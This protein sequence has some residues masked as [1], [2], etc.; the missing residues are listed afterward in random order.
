MIIQTWGARIPLLLLAA[1]TGY[2]AYLGFAPYYNSF[3]LYVSLFFY[4]FFFQIK[5]SP[6]RG[7]YLIPYVWD[8]AFSF[9][10]LSWMNQALNFF[11]DLPFGVSQLVVLAI[12]LGL[13]IRSLIIAVLWNARARSFILFPL[14]FSGATYL[15]YNLVANFSWLNFAYTNTNQLG[16]YLAPIGGTYLVQFFQIAF[17]T[18]VYALIHKIIISRQQPMVMSL[19]RQTIDRQLRISWRTDFLALFLLSVAFVSF[20]FMHHQYTHLSKTPISVALVQPNFS[21]HNREQLENQPAM[22]ETYRN[23][24]SKTLND[25][26]VTQPPKLWILPESALM[27]FYS[28]DNNPAYA[29]HPLVASTLGYLSSIY[30]PLTLTH[31]DLV[32]G[33]LAVKTEEQKINN[34]NAALVL[35]NPAVL[36]GAVNA[37][38]R[39]E[40]LNG[41]DTLI[42]SYLKE[43]LVP[44]G[45][46]VPFAWLIKHLPIPGI[47]NQL[48]SPFIAGNKYQ[49]NIKTQFSQAA[50]II[51]Y[52]ALFSEQL[53]RQINQDTS[54]L[55]NI[56]N[57]V[58]FGHEQG[59]AQH[60]NV[61]RF[62][63]LESQRYT[64]RAT[65]NGITAI[66][67]PQGQIENYLPQN[68]AAVLVG[69]Y[70]NATGVTPYQEYSRL[71]NFALAALFLLA[72]GFIRISVSL[73]TRNNRN[74]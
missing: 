10:T 50:M 20:H 3:A 71:M 38:N 1:F 35:T 7:S 9:A 11:G 6:K 2:F 13:G 40:E 52:D 44:F 17:I 22:V 31:S 23:L 59:P 19:R 26:N 47:E 25:P 5:A 24:I 8:V 66:I 12:S 48:A 64:L 67:N 57:D 16:V 36:P 62:R 34:Y 29:Q 53:I 42:Q 65:N 37:P 14:L 39:V 18:F 30:Q 46:Y 49:P 72:V 63:S 28:L 32:L 27:S 43:H 33:I 55:I 21:S 4:V 41:Q 51:C 61:A 68:Q 69:N 56:S 54:V 70:Y 60:L 58:W 73:V 74:V 15:W 45:E